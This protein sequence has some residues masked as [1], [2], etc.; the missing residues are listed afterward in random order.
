MAK[1][2]YYTLVNKNGNMITT[3]HK[4]PI[5]WIKKVAERYA[6]IF[7]A[8]AVPIKKAEI[9]AIIKNQIK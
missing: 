1:T 2:L 6:E 9:E 4:L 5:Y 8:F 3:D 7:K